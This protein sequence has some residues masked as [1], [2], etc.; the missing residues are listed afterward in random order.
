M[1]YTPQGVCSRQINFELDGDIIKS[2][3]FVGGCAGNTQGVARLIEGMNVEDAITRIDGIQCGFKGTS[4]PD[5]LAR[6]LKE[7]IGK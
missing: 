7:A 5:Q 3:E 1:Q 2:V 4:C 6:A